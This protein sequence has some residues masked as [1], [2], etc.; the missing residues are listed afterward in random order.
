LK[1]DLVQAISRRVLVV[2][3]NHINQIVIQA[4]LKKDGHE[5]LLVSDGAQAVEAV[6][7]GEFDLVLMDM[8]MPVMNGVDATRAIRQLGAAVRDIPIVALTANAMTEDVHRCHD[9]GMND[10][11]A[12]PI[13]REL[14]RRALNIWGGDRVAAILEEGRSRFNMSGPAPYNYVATRARFPHR[15]SV[16]DVAHVLG[17][18]G[19]DSRSIAQ[20]LVDTVVDY[21]ICFLE[22]DGTVKSWNPGAQR[23]KGYS[24]QE[25]IGTNFSVFYTDDDI[26]AGE[27]VR[28]LETARTTGR[29]ETKGWRVRKDGTRFWA[30]VLIDA[31]RNSAGEVVGFAKTTRDE[32]RRSDGEVVGFVNV[33]RDQTNVRLLTGQV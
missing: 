26:R 14:L 20:M 2:D 33:G 25:I 11:L 21:A 7:T 18:L 27:P 13:D 10:H 1:C 5:V 19:E 22:L 4:L 6:Q 29:F 31:V 24:A 32:V 12:K 30:S 28:S 23:I 17:H 9:A 8:Q 3:D 15:N 16:G